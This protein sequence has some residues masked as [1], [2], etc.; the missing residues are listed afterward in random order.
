MTEE[1]HISVG[2]ANR[3]KTIKIGRIEKNSGQSILAEEKGETLARR[4]N[5]TFPNVCEVWAAR[6]IDGKI[7]EKGEPFINLADPK[8]RGELIGLKW[9]DP[10]GSIMKA[11]YIRGLQSLDMLYQDRVLNYKINEEDESSADA[12]FLSYPNGDIDFDNTSDPYLVQ[13]LKWHAWNQNSI[14][15][16]PNF[17][18]NAFFEKTFEQQERLDT[19]NWDDEFEA[20]KI[21]R[22]AGDSS[23]SV[24]RC[25]NLLSIVKDITDEEPEDKNVYSYLKMISQKR[26]PQFLEAIKQY[27]LR[28]SDVFSKMDSYE[29]ADYTVDGTLVVEDTVGKGKNANKVQKI[30]L[31]DLPVKGR[32]IYDYM[33]ENFCEPKIFD[34]IFDLIQITDKIK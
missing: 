21:V 10:R 2:H 31:T 33:L 1:Y 27:K 3:L 19:Q 6:V 25:K 17:Y 7:P 24:A 5:F 4:G 34:V 28:V 22:E 20:M 18:D 12:Y 32:D 15:R 29:I 8:Y 11:R 9:G 16:S 23:E 30:V 26:A 13:H 14:S